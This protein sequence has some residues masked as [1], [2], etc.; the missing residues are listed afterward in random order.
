MSSKLRF[1]LLPLAIVL[2]IALG[3]GVYWFL[4]SRG[5]VKYPEFISKLLPWEET[6]SKCKTL[7]T[8]E[9]FCLYKSSIFGFSIEYPNDWKSFEEKGTDGTRIQ[10]VSLV[11]AE[12]KVGVYGSELYSGKVTT[13]VRLGG[14]SYYAPSPFMEIYPSGFWGGGFP[15][16]KTLSSERFITIRGIKYKILRYSG[17]SVF[18]LPNEVPTPEGSFELLYSA[19]LGSSG[20]GTLDEMFTT[21]KF[22]K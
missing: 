3:G 19:N 10:F 13:T 22:L 6:A 12:V 20:Y 1:L 2:A 9:G 21:L 18:V 5:I 7:G 11:G 14:E 16:F 8:K 17:G 15:P 4:Q